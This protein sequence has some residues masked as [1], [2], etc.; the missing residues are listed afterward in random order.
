MEP[1]VTESRPLRDQLALLVI[2]IA[3]LAL[4]VLA[5]IYIGSSDSDVARAA[6]A[7]KIF[8]ALLPLVGTWVG[9]VLA[10]YF[11]RE[12][13]I[14]ASRSV[15]DM[16]R[17]ISA[18]DRS[19]MTAAQIMT[20]RADMPVLKLPADGGEDKVTI[21]ELKSLFD[22]HR[23]RVAILAADDS[24]KYVIHE[25][26]FTRFALGQAE[27]HLAALKLAAAAPAQPNTLADF[28][29]A[30]ITAGRTVRHVATAFIIVRKAEVAGRISAL[31][32]AEGAQDAFVTETG[33][34]SEAV[35]GWIR[36]DELVKS[37][38]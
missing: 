4:T 21:Q 1:P 26:T 2:G 35:Q 5:G 13:F 7:D 8:G 23:A 32:L 3:V 31:L 10:F 16:A 22:G 38:G 12:N 20:P 18:P 33:L 9:T 34:R 11:G 15:S 6:A 14:A 37:A 30:E 29:N 27:E 24:V 25:A 19:R 28:L 17:Q 36:F